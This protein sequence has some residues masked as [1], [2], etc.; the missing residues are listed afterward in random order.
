[1]KFVDLHAEYL[2]YKED[3]DK[4]L[5]EV[6]ESGRYLLGPQLQK[7][8]KSFAEL[9]EKDIAVGVK[10]CTD[11][12]MLVLKRVH[13]QNMP[14]VIPN[15]GAYPTAVACKNI[16]DNI[17]YVDVDRT[18]T[19][20]VSKLPDVRNGIVIPV[21]MFGNNCDM[22]GVMQYAK[23]NNHIVVEDC[24]Q[25]TGSG[26]GRRG[27][28]SVF[29]FYPTKPLASMGDGG[30]IC[31]NRHEGEYFRKVR[32]YGQSGDSVELVGINSRMDEF[33][34]AIVNAKISRFK[35]LIGVRREICK[36]YLEVSKG[37]DWRK[38]SVFH[39]FVV[40]VDSR[41]KYL[42]DLQK[43]EIPY[44]I[45]YPRHVSELESLGG[46]NGEVGYRFNDKCVSLP[47]HPFMEEDDIQK[48]EEFLWNHREYEV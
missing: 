17:H 40:L 39:Q 35:E 29:S 23:E 32:F 41:D 28:Y 44:M 36:R 10:N 18:G 45:H 7:L 25:S 5:N 34:S 26:S 8:E 21:H 6:I 19:M 20:D 42:K 27:E 14:I 47:C 24:A 13:K 3:I 22:D 12:I 43:E 46:F 4:N 48:V 1:M 11:A 33:Q 30:M 37:I 15:F 2:F 16:S 9:V 38:D 31:T